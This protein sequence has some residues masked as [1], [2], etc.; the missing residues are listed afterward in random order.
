MR[1]TR[2]RR[3]T[4]FCHEVIVRVSIWS[5]L[6]IAVRINDHIALG[7]FFFFLLIYYY[8]YE[9]EPCVY[10]LLSDKSQTHDKHIFTRIKK[11]FNFVSKLRNPK[12]LFTL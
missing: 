11:Y 10:P 8:Y 1:N 7:F 12:K 3:R 5:F 9:D 4:L 2:F 6:A